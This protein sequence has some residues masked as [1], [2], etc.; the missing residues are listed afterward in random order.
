MLLEFSVQ[1]IFQFVSGGYIG[2]KDLPAMHLCVVKMSLGG[3]GKLFSEYRN[4]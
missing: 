4:I 3:R 2:M 1:L